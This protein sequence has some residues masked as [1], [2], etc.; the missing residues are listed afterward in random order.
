VMADLVHWVPKVLLGGYVALHDYENPAYGVKT[1]L[2]E[3]CHRNHRRIHLLPED[4][5][6]DAGAYF[7]VDTV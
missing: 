3:Y 4:K 6:E 7:Y 5:P 1:A 2:Q